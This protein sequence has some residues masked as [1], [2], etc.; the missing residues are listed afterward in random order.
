[1]AVRFEPD[2][3]ETRGTP[4]PV[5]VGVRR[6]ANGQT[7]TA[8]MAISENGTL[9]Y[10]TGPATVSADTRRL[11]VGNGQIEPEVLKV[12]PG[13]YTHPRVSPDGKLLAVARSDGVGVSDIWTY[14]MSGTSEM[15]RL[16]FGGQSHDPVWSADSRR[17][18]FQSTRDAAAGI[19]WQAADGSGAP[20]RLTASA[21]GEE[22]VPESW[23]RD[24]ARLLFSRLKDSEYVLWVFTRD[25]GKIEPF[26]QVT[27]A[28][29]LS[30]TFS[31]DGR[32]VAYASTGQA[33]GLV[34]PDRGVFV[35]PF[36]A[37]GEKHQ[38]PKR[39]LDFHPVWSPEGRR[40]F[41]VPAAADPTVSVEVRMRPSIAFGTP[42]ELPR[43]PRPRVTSSGVRGYDVFPDGRFV[44]LGSLPGEGAADQQF[45]QLRVV[46]NWTEELKQLVPAAP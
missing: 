24:G 2:T 20:E 45:N 18:T 11:I 12:S 42:V 4:V 26:G 27:S 34:S 38:A 35:E 39:R 36:P 25:G 30:A 32:W 16:T 19:F 5:V 14:D 40:L 15:R 37:T 1:M 9:V 8:H 44:S 7:G 23:S 3:L 6:S 41:Y 22:H 33:G 29:R 28:E 21:Q 46:L 31:P 43:H 10:L 13:S 17:V